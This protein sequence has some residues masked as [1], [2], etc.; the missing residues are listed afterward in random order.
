MDQN[1]QSSCLTGCMIGIMML[2]VGLAVGGI[3]TYAVIDQLYPDSSPNAMLTEFP[4]EAI[5][6]N[7]SPVDIQPDPNSSEFT[8]VNA[9]GQTLPAVVTVINQSGRNSGNGSGFFISTNGYIVT[10]NHVV[11]GAGKISIIYAQGGIVP[12]RLIGTA[13]EFDLAVIKIDGI[14][15]AVAAW[16]D[17]SALPLG[18]EVIAIGSALGRY[19]NTVTAGVLSGFNRELGGLRGLLQTDAAINHGNSGGPVINLAGQ[20]VGINTMVVRGDFRGSDEAQGLGFA[21]PSNIAQ[22]VVQRLIEDGKVKPPFLGIQ[23]QPLNPQLA[24]ETNLSLTEGAY[25]DA[26]FD[27]TPASNAGIQPEDVIISVADQKIDDRHPLVSEL[28]EHAAGDTITIGI[29]RDR[30]TIELQLTLMERP[31]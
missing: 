25:V 20:V 26:V 7:Q 6:I 27:G 4:L 23:Y 1:R 10:N 31:E 30:H 8:M 18:S 29:L 28:F 3:T 22:N 9:V 17:S 14:V 12:A 2:F 11:E 13:P 21:I 19:Q 5:N 16:G 15:P 24:V